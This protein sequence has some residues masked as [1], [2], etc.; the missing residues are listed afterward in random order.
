MINPQKNF[1]HYPKSTSHIILDY[2]RSRCLREATSLVGFIANDK[3]NASPEAQSFFSYFLF[4][5]APSFRLFSSFVHASFVELFSLFY[6][7]LI[8]SII[9]YFFPFSPPRIPPFSFPYL[10]LSIDL[11]SSHSLSFLPPPPSFFLLVYNTSVSQSSLSLFSLILSKYTLPPLSVRISPKPLLNYLL[12][13][14]IAFFHV[15]P[16][17]PSSLPTLNPIGRA[18]SLL[19][20]S[21]CFSPVPPSILS[22]RST[23]NGYL[24]TSPHPLSPYLVHSVPFDPLPSPHSPQVAKENRDYLDEGNPVTYVAPVR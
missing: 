4:F 23:P 7:Y 19:L 24:S 10:F 15:P 6:P 18:P 2:F 12:S 20:I 16:P 1:I 3:W 13:V 11:S 17:L 8:P 5:S 21:I 9:K 14:L 22:L